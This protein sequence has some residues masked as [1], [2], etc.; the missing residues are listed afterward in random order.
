MPTK[1]KNYVVLKESIRKRSYYS[2]S[3]L[4]GTIVAFNKGWR[5]YSLFPT[6][7][8]SP[9]IAAARDYFPLYGRNQTLAL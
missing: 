5:E 4:A 6:S 7:L 1:N 9:S 3:C 8:L 2:F